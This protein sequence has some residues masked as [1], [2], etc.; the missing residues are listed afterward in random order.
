MNWE[1]SRNLFPHHLP[2]ILR[3]VVDAGSLSG[4]WIWTS[5]AVSCGLV[6]GPGPVLQC[7]VN[8]CGLLLLHLRPLAAAAGVV[9]SGMKSSLTVAGFRMGPS[10]MGITGLSW[11]LLS[12][13]VD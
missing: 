10:K 3:V 13:C 12:W 9:G 4:L 8:L 7:L 6:C 1:P 11:W 5:S 2:S